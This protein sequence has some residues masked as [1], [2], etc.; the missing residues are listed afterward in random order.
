MAGAQHGMAL[1]WLAWITWPLMA[2]VQMMCVGG[3]SRP[4]HTGRG[5]QCSALR[6]RHGDR[7]GFQRQFRSNARQGI[8]TS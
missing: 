3:R 6:R 2:A 8:S 1:L 4:N 5:N 7:R